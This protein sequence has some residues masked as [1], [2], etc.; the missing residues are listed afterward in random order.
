MMWHLL[1]I[2]IALHLALPGLGQMRNA[3][4]EERFEAWLDFRRSVGALGSA[5]DRQTTTSSKWALVVGG[6][7]KLGAAVYLT[8]LLW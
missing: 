7:F 8:S 3:L 6:V 5:R 1:V 2:L 4:N